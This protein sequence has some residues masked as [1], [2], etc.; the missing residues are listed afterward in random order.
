MGATAR[1][2]PNFTTFWA[3]GYIG[4][5]QKIGGKS[6]KR[7]FEFTVLSASAGGDS[8]KLTKVRAHEKVV[9]LFCVTDGLGASAGAGRTFEIGDSV[10][11]DRL[12]LASDFDLVNA[13]G[14]LRFLGAGWTPTEDTDIVGTMH[15]TN[16][17]VVGKK[18]WGWIEVATVA[19]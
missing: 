15:A 2:A 9:G 17:A 19:G 16:A 14:T 18:V 13:V 3:S 7:F 4:G 5:A 1:E 12:M 11:P 6:E 10:D 8:Y